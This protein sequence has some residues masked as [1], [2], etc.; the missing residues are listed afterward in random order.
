MSQ[1]LIA[2]S[3]L[4][5]A[6]RLLAGLKTTLNYPSVSAVTGRFPAYLS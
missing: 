2:L 3:K 4:A 6:T 1:I 5:L